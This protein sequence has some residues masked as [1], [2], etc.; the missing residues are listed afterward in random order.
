MSEMIKYAGR[1]LVARWEK[2]DRGLLRANGD[3]A[4]INFGR[5]YR[6]HK[7]SS[8]L[9]DAVGG[10]V[11]G[12]T[13]GLI[14]GKKPMQAL[15]L[16]APIRVSIEE[17][18]EDTGVIIVRPF[19]PNRDVGDPDKTYA[20][21]A[22]DLMIDY[23][24]LKEKMLPKSAGAVDPGKKYAEFFNP[25]NNAIVR[26]FNSTAGKGLACAINSLKF[27]W[28]DNVTWETEVYGSRAPKVCKVSLTLSPIHD[29]AP[30]ID[31]DGMNRAPVYNVGRR[32]NA[33]AGDGA[34]DTRDSRENFN[35]LK[36]AHNVNINKHNLNQGKKFK[37]L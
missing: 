18:D 17:V 22:S 16:T 15:V 2:D 32:V 23:E 1:Q 3:P 35:T 11:S 12:A 28:L 36:N 9:G 5:G 34:D 6:E 13:G 33:L 8:A 24:F 30:G 29:I 37:I 25:D 10:A 14:G 31:A 19:A 26:A 7:K 27:D 21:Y 20:V 4:S